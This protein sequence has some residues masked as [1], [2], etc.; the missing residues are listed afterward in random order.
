MELVAA[1]LR[2]GELVEGVVVVDARG[3]VRSV[4]GDRP[5]SKVAT[6]CVPP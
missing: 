5:A 2:I 1:A 6:V 4:N 3:R